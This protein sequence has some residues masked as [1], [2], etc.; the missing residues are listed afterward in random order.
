MRKIFNNEAQAL[1]DYIAHEAEYNTFVYGDVKNFGL[2]GNNVEV[3]VKDGTEEYEL[4]ILRYIDDFIVYAKNDNYNALEAV[5][6]L[7]TKKARCI[8]GKASIVKQLAMHMPTQKCTTTHLSRVSRASDIKPT[9]KVDVLGADKSKDIVALFCQIDEFEAYNESTKERYIKELEAT[10]GN[11]S[12]AFGVFENDELC[13][14]ARTTAETDLSAMVVGVATLPQYRGK[15]YAVACVQALI[16]YC[17]GEK[18]MKFVCLFY[19][20]LAAGRIYHKAGFEDIGEYVLI[21]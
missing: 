12:H 17:I 18:G 7:K 16:E 9:V 3:F 10:L 13:A 6:F 4:I 21:S 20:N 2:E 14:I 15:G 5:S 11:M 1:Y 8:S 19:D